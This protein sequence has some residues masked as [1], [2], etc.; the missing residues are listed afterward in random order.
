MKTKYNIYR[1]K[2]PTKLAK[3]CE[4]ISNNFLGV[5]VELPFLLPL[6]SITIKYLNSPIIDF[7]GEKYYML[8]PTSKICFKSNYTEKL[9]V[10][11]SVINITEEDESAKYLIWVNNQEVYK[12][13]YNNCETTGFMKFNFIGEE[14]INAIWEEK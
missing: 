13:L 2:F 5:F 11:F 4:Y 10:V 6:K 14:I 7:Y 3:I 8:A 12:Y 1:L 9:H